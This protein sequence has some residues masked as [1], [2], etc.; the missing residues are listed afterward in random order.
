MRST[1]RVVAA[2]YATFTA[3]NMCAAGVATA[4]SAQPS[5]FAQPSTGTTATD[6]RIDLAPRLVPR[7]SWRAILRIDST[8]QVFPPK[9]GEPVGTLT[10]S[11][12]YEMTVL[13]I[14]VEPLPASAP[15]AIECTGC[16]R[17]EIE[18]SAIDSV[19]KLK[20]P[21]GE[22]ENRA[23]WPPATVES[24]PPPPR[25]DQSG[26]HEVEVKTFNPKVQLWVD[27]SGAIVHAEPD[28]EIAGGERADLVG[29]MQTPR[30]ITF[31]LAPMFQAIPAREGGPSTAPGETWTLTRP[32]DVPA[33][34]TTC[35]ISITD[36]RTLERTVGSTA[37]IGTSAAGAWEREP[38][39]P[40]ATV[41]LAST[42]VI[43][44]DLVRHLLAR[45]TSGTTMTIVASPSAAA[46]AK[47]GETTTGPRGD[48][49]RSEIRMTT[50]LTVRP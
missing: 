27:G 25:I 41:T 28:A 39:V 43:E 17:V 29:P 44:W 42:G 20:G 47:N 22:V 49:V 35:A 50:S 31:M 14:G 15:A 3:M 9:A 1:H 32:C 5:T 2:A 45:Q 37:R 18:F 13:V 16:T 38:L 34:Q 21:I 6:T 23:T 10:H 36:T 24:A 46:A 40:G 48:E 8:E 19:T 11:R 26:V 4:A 30:D 33:L 7:A 12:E